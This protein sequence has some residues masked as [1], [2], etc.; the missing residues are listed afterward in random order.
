[1]FLIFKP[2][3]ARTDKQNSC[4]SSSAQHNG[5]TLKIW[6]KIQCL[7]Q[8]C[9]P[10]A[11]DKGV[12]TNTWFISLVC[13]FQSSFSNGSCSRCN[14]FLF[15][16]QTHVLEACTYTCA[17]QRR[18]EHVCVLMPDVVSASL[19]FHS[20]L[21]HNLV[22]SNLICPKRLLTHDPAG[23]SVPFKRTIHPLYRRSM[24]ACVCTSV[25]VYYTDWSLR[26]HL[27]GHVWE[28]KKKAKDRS[29]L[30]WSSTRQ[31]DVG[32]QSESQRCRGI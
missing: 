15:S 25:C 16:S 31:T 6:K 3:W 28:S 19:V 29:N 24:C 26:P 27:H 4:W 13:F 5:P 9:F 12:S 30:P 20:S 2:R 10:R 21:E 7:Q 32:C 11:S 14:T 17:H 1:M 18:C 23:L 22:Y 8:F